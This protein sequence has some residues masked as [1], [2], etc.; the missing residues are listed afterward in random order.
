MCFSLYV[1]SFTRSKSGSMD[2]LLHIPHEILN[3]VFLSIQFYR[4]TNHRVYPVTPECENNARFVQKV[5]QN[6]AIWQEFQRGR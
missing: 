6:C 5:T 3:F 2:I 1:I 4:Y